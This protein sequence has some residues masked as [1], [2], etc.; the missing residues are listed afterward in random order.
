[1]SLFL[2]LR[3]GLCVPENRGSAKN[4]FDA[5]DRNLLMGRIGILFDALNYDNNPSNFDSSKFIKYIDVFKKYFDEDITDKIRRALLCISDDNGK[6]NYYD[7]WWSYSYAVE[8]EKRCLI[9]K[10]KELEYF[11]YGTYKD[12]NHFKKYFLKLLNRLVEE[13]IDSIIDNF[14]KPE[15]MPGWKYKLIKNNELLEIHC[16]SKYIAIKSDNSCAYLLRG[17][18][19][20]T[21]DGCYKIGND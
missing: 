11:I 12:R 6:H 14:E 9:A 18:R 15:N 2:C 3:V 4:I 1:M 7:Y 20:R 16:R 19:P 10:Y 17:V 21:I 13:S 8:S 5:E